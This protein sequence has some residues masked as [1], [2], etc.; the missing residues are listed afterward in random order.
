MKK[1][2]AQFIRHQA[3]YCKAFSEYQ[4]GQKFM[5]FPD[6]RVP[7]GSKYPTF[8]LAYQKGFNN[9]LG[10]DVDFDKWNFSDC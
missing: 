1:S 2:T 3:C 5:Q 4:P 10:S 9:I 8:T 7:L 6:Y